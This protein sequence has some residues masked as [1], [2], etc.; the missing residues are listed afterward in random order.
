MYIGIDGGGTKTKAMLLDEHLNLIHTE[1][2]GPSSIRTV[3]IEESLKNIH[4]CIDRCAEKAKKSIE[5]VFA[6]LGDVAGKDDETYM[7]ECLK[8]NKHLSNAMVKVKN[9]VYN[10]H[11]GALEGEPGIALIIGTGSVAFGVDE[12][13]NAHRAGGYSYKEGDL[14]SAYGLGSLAMAY[15]GKAYDGRVEGSALT[16]RLLEYFSINSFFDMVLMYEEYYTRRTSVASLG[17]IVTSYAEHAD[18]VALDLIETSTDEMMLMIK[19]ID[20]KLD[21]KNKA[22]AI[23]GSL[24]QSQGIYRKRLLEKIEDYDDAYAMFNAKKDPAFGAA[25]LARDLAG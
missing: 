9:D 2:A 19:G 16:E 18:P 1:E 15:M 6:G 17:K 3:S 14:G 11:N 22:I 4:T 10:A 25:L 21:L 13:G 12:A 20:K 24:G 5:S 23:S 7:V 8:E